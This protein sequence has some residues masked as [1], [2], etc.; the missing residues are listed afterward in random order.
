MPRPSSE[1]GS[2]PAAPARGPLPYTPAADGVRLRVHVSPRASR[3]RIGE[4]VTDGRTA[5]LR[6][7]VTAPPH[8]GE[9]NAAVIA[10]LARALRLPKSALS[11]I[12]GHAGREKT[13]AVR[14]D[15][16]SLA[17]GIDALLA[18]EQER[19]R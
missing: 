10:L 3:E 8:E 6:L 1:A 13:I 5:R 15:A 18:T 7:A 12:A 2:P 11:V 19:R 9:A 16:T 14:G 4:V 17:A